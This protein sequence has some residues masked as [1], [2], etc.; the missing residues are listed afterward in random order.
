MLSR[1][2]TPVPEVCSRASALDAL[3]LCS[4]RRPMAQ[5]FISYA[6]EDQDFAEVVQAKLERAGHR[7][8]L[9]LDLLHAGDDWGDKLDLAIRGA[10]ALVL[11]LTPDARQSV[12]VA[13]EWAFA[14]GAGVRLIVLDLIA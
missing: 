5:V 11:V 8:S 3:V 7:T 9:D 13:Y 4:G 10:H 6:R 2:K 12:Y 14:L 1:V